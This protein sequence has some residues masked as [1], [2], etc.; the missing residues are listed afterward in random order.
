MPDQP[1]DGQQSQPPV[2]VINQPSG[3]V[4]L[5]GSMGL[6]GWLAQ[7]GNL[8][9]MAIIAGTFLWLLT[10]QVQQ[11]RVDR[12]D[13]RQLFRESVRDIQTRADVRAGEIRGSTDANTATLRELIAEL[14]SARK[15]GLMRADSPAPAAPPGGGGP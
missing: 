3:P 9:A 12:L 5:A 13:D 4:S 6:K 8:T 11:A 1:Q 14:R 7:A 2:Q 10:Q 15:A